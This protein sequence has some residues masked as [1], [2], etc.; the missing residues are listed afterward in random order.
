V[1]ANIACAPIPFRYGYDR[2]IARQLL[3]V[4]VPYALAALLSAALL[5]VD[6]LAIGSVLG[7]TAVGLYLVA[8]NVSSWPNTL[9][10]AAVRSVAIP[11]FSR[12]HHDGVGVSRSLN[13]GLAMLFAGAV[14]FAAILIAVPDAVVG[15][16]YG[17]R[18][19]PGAIALPFLAV[20]SL[21]RL[22][23]GLSEDALFA[24]GRSSWL[25]LKNGCWLVALLIALPLAAHVD[26]IRGVGI[27]HAVVIVAMVVPITA[28]F[29]LRSKLW[30]TELIVTL[31]ALAACGAVAGGC[32]RLVCRQINAAPFLVAA[33][34]T[35]IVVA[36]YGALVF[37]FRHRFLRRP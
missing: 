7:P 14:P 20:M 21:V 22:L 2:R 34:A 4:S 25:L 24:T 19:V 33:A 36:V 35:L 29:L 1:A 23:D 28:L 17:E 18:W 9:I 8:F 15:A 26:G 6:Y 10:G 37:P 27:G 5:N 12:L 31:C 32:A 30:R 13:Y 11:S 3:R 16:L